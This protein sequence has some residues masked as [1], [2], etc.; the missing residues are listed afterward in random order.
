[1]SNQQ[2]LLIWIINNNW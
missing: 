2:Q 1:M